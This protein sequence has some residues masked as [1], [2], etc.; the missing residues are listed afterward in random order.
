MMYL[1]DKHF[2]KRSI[3]KVL[4]LLAAGMRLTKWDKMRKSSK[5]SLFA[6]GIVGLAMLGGASRAAA[7]TKA[8]TGPE[9]ARPGGGLA[10]I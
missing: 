4:P 6:G 3:K 5:M 10:G 8:S 1:K 2:S 7:Q 9:S